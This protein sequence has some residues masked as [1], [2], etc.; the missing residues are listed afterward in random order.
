M[1][2]AAGT[3]LGTYQITSPLGAGGMGEVYRARDTRLGREVAIKVLPAA[4]SASPDR[5]ARFEREARTVAGLSHPNI[6]TLFSVEEESGT[7]FL[8]MELVEGKSLDQHLTPGGLPLSRVLDLAIPLAGALVAAHERGVVHRDLKPGN[9]MVT[10]DGWVKV[11]DFGLAKIA[12]EEGVDLGATIGATAGPISGAGQVLGT[13]PYMAPEQIR[14]ET[15]DAR[16]DLFALGIILYE[17]TTGRRPFAGATSADVSSAILRDVPP[18]VVSLRGDLPRDLNRIITRCLEK[19]PKDRFQTARDVMNELRYVLRE[20]AL[21]ESGA[22]PATLSP[23][24]PAG[25]PSST[26]SHTGSHASPAPSSRPSSMSGAPSGGAQGQDVPSIAVLPFVNRSRGEEDEYFSDGLAD[27]LLNVLTKIRGL[28]VAARASSFQFKGKNEDL[29]L[30]GEKLNVATLL[31]GSVRKAGNRI[32][33]SVQ[34]IMAADRVQLWSETYDRSLEDIFAVQDDIAQSVVKELRSTLLGEVPDSKASGV[35][36]DEVAVAAKGHGSNP[37]AHRLYLQG[38][39]FLD[40]LTQEDT[41][42][43]MRYLRE[44]LALD[45]THAAAWTELARAYSVSGGYGW[46]NVIEGYQNAREAVDRALEIQ[47]N[48]P[49]AH[50]MLSIIQR[51]HQWDWEGSE[52]SVRR[53]LELAPGDAIVLRS[54]GIL[55]ESAGRFDEAERYIRKAIE[56]DPLNPMAYSSLGNLYRIMD[57]LPE[58]EAAY[59]KALELAPHRIATRMVLSNCLAMQGK[60][61]EA[62]TEANA[63]PAEWARLTALGFVHHVAGRTAEYQEALRKLEET[64]AN[65]AAYQIAAL[66]SVG[67]DRDGAFAWLGRA[68][69]DH[70]AGLFQVKREPSFRPL[71]GDPRWSPL[72]KKIGLEA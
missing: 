34:L 69:E 41:T 59:R 17:L 33:V 44:A 4:V 28:R 31:D 10:H 67:G 8:T 56:Q 43:G 51:V 36:R 25:T 6:V 50:V 55:A 71:H 9:V 23:T 65:D 53:A 47:P 3:R 12:T 21:A 22:S 18:S 58:A 66:R 57:R 32:R 37:E 14:G 2:L 48:L 7:R 54:A 61:A 45:P 52:R 19:N 1:S 26:P 39:Y 42:N 46:M 60:H 13:V 24:S 72:L 30:I 11:L 62:L 40:R 5:L 68:Y 49:E 35:A 15:V 64:N 29:A 70:D 16:A 63:E 20:T 38:K 27:E